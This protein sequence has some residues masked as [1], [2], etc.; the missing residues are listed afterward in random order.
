MP[1]VYSGIITL[2][3]TVLVYYFDKRTILG[4]WKPFYKQTIY[5]LL[6]AGAAIFSTEFGGMN[7]SGAIINVRDAA[8]VLGGLLFGP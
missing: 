2:A 6:F 8:V 4:K 5:G 3:I 1:L 7:Y